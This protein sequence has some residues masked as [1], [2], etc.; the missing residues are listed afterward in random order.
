[1]RLRR[2]GINPAL[3]LLASATTHMHVDY[4]HFTDDRRVDRGIPSFQGRPSGTDIH[5]FFGD[6]DV[7]HS[8]ARVDAAGA[9]V[10]HAIGAVTLKNRTRYVKYDKFYQNVFPGAVDASGTQVS[11]AGYNNGTGRT[12][13]FNQTD[14]TLDGWTGRVGHTLLVGAELGRQGTDNFRETGY[15]G[16][17]ATSTSVPFAQPT[18]STGVVFRQSATDA[19]S[20]VRTDVGALYA[21]DQITLSP[22]WQAIVGLRVDRFDLRFHNNRNGQDLSRDDQLVSP[23]AGLIFKPI[24]PVSFYGSY[25]VSHLP[26]AGDQFSSLTV[27]TQTLQPERFNNYELGAKWDV[28]P[29]LSLTSAVFRLDRTNSQATDPNDPSRIVQTGAQRTTGYELGVSGNLSNAWEIAGGYSAQKA[30][31]VSTTTAAKAGASVPLVPRQTVSLWNKYQVVPAAGVGLGLIHQARMY[32]A[33]DN[34]VTLPAFT[35]VDGALFLGVTRFVRVQLN[36]ENLFDTKYYATSQG[37]N[38]ILPGAERTFRLSLSA[39]L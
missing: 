35:R 32:A 36:V 4:E 14:V 15:F 24:E 37:N 3:T 39:G 23:R 16:G 20:H 26:S 2:Q 19:D 11:L 33:I 6:P 31:I 5:T 27:T 18:R 13:L 34:T 9:V 22:N 21:Q 1:M 28:S 7:S 25:S 29:A 10:E 38:N 12:N 17:N 30:E 8:N